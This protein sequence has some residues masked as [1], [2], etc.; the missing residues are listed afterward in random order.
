MNIM[1]K[2]RSTFKLTVSS[3]SLDGS[4][5]DILTLDISGELYFFSQSFLLKATP[6]VQA[7]Y[8]SSLFS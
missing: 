8:T 1:N 4:V 5:Y 3:F 2:L 7:S 6:K